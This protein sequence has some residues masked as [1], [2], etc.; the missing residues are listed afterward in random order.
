MDSV[1]KQESEERR[2]I[3]EE[4]NKKLVYKTLA[5]RG[6]N[7]SV[8]YPPPVAALV[9]ED[10]PAA[11]VSFPRGLRATTTADVMKMWVHCLGGDG[12]SVGDC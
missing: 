9:C 10:F 4:D 11:L 12:G 1:R 7:F 5:R 6:P 2:H 3:P 8:R